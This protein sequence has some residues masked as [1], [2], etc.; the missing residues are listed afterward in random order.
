LVCEAVNFSKFVSAEPVAEHP[1]AVSGFRECEENAAIV[2]SLV[3]HVM[4]CCVGEFCGCEGEEENVTNWD[5][6]R[7]GFSKGVKTPFHGF[8]YHV[9]IVFTVVIT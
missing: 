4:K 3:F 7:V 5:S 8:F 1:E 6:E 9:I 2:G